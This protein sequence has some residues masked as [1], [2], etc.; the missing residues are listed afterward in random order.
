MN[1][2][3]YGSSKNF[4]I[5]KKIKSISLNKSVEKFWKIRNIYVAEFQN[6]P[7]PKKHTKKKNKKTE[8][9]N[10]IFEETKNIKNI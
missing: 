3:N 7:P 1:T 8:R 4:I 5:K 6:N 9:V 10:R 2:F